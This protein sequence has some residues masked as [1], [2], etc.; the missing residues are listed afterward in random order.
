MMLAPMVVWPQEVSFYGAMEHGDV[1]TA[2]CAG[3]GGRHI[4]RGWYKGLM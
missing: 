1:G 4:L 2:E 3:C